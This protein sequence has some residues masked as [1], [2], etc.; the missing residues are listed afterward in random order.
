MT[1]NIVACVAIDTAQKTP[2]VCSCLV[3]SACYDSTILALSEYAR[4]FE[5]FL[6]Y[7]A[8]VTATRSLKKKIDTPKQ[9]H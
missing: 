6:D 5:V 2:F 9:V 7:H 8:V 1:Y 3:A 4:I